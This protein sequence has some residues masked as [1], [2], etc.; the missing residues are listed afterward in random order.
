MLHPTEHWRRVA[1][2]S[3]FQGVDNCVVRPL[4]ENLFPTDRL[5][6]YN[7][8]TFDKELGCGAQGTVYKYGSFQRFGN[9]RPYLSIH[10]KFPVIR[11]TCKIKLPRLPRLP[12]MAKYSWYSD[13]RQ[14]LSLADPHVMNVPESAIGGGKCLL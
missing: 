7:A 13:P 10:A 9:I 2:R 3:G 5:L 6:D 8:F 4:L 1:L 12:I 14:Q 11:Y